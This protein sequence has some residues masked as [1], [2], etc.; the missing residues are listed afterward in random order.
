MKIYEGSNSQAGQESFVLNSLKEKRGGFYVEIGG[1]HSK[2]DSNTYLLETKYDWKGVAL[3]IDKE[4]SD[5]YNL[6]RSNI[7]LNVD[8]TIFDYLK[9]FEEN[10]FPKTIDYLQV[11]IEPAYQSLKALESLP[12]DKYRFSVITFEHDIYFDS[13]NILIKEKSKEILSKFNYT[14]AVEDVKAYGKTF[15]DWWLDS[16]IINDMEKL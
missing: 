5:E 14:L 15:E 6:N 1:Y 3:E 13:D 9:Y 8:A 10:N 2:N 16:N 7:C 4:R 11:D 12:L